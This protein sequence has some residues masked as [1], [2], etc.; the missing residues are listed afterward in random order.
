MDYS[1]TSGSRILCYTVTD[2]AWQLVRGVCTN[3]LC[4]CQMW[5][6][7]WWANISTLVLF[8]FLS[9]VFTML[10]GHANLSQAAVFFL[11]RKVFTPYKPL[12][13]SFFFFFCNCT[14]MNFIYK[15]FTFFVL[16]FFMLDF[17][18]S[19]VCLPCVLLVQIN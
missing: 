15:K 17:L 14:V 3:M 13:I 10:K 11:E 16:F 19:V 2:H 1:L 6:C 9:L 8:L 12:F 5:C 7:A 18:C 4:F